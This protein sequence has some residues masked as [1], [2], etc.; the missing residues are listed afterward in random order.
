VSRNVALGEMVGAGSDL[1]VREV[2]EQGR[3]TEPKIADTRGI[4]R[5]PHIQQIVAAKRG[6]V[7]RISTTLRLWTL[8][9]SAAAAGGTPARGAAFIRASVTPRISPLSSRTREEGRPVELRGAA[10]IGTVLRRRRPLECRDVRVHQR[11]V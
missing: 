6:L 4:G 1:V 9:S 2:D 11:H 5:Q 8:C 10:K 3:L 7:V